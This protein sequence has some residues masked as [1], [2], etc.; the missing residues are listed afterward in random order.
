MRQE[1]RAMRELTDAVVRSARGVLDEWGEEGYE[2]RWVH[3]LPV[4]PTERA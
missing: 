3:Y 4:A 2:E 1:A